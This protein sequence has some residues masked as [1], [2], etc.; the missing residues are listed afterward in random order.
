[1]KTFQSADHYSL[2]FTVIMP[3]C[4]GGDNLRRSLEALATSTR[5]PDEVIV[6]DDSS[7]DGSA[8]MARNYEVKVI[9]ISDGSQGS[10]VARNLGAKAAQGNIL[11]FIDADV[12]VR[13]DTLA[14]IERYLIKHPEIDALFGSYDA[15]PAVRTLVS[16][17][18]NLLHHYVHQHSPREASTFWTGCGAIRRE[19]FDEMGG[20]DISCRTIRD[21]ELGGR[22][23]RAGKQVWLCPEIQVKHL[24]HWKLTTMIR[25]D[26]FDRAIPW[27]RLIVGN[28]SMP[29]ELNL[30]KGNLVSASAAWMT[31]GFLVTGF[32]FPW[33]WIGMVLSM[34]TLG[35][36]NA[37]LYHF[38]F[39]QGGLGFAAGAAGLHFLYLLYSSMTFALISGQTR[40]SPKK[41]QE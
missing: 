7:S 34:V 5:P 29:N 13:S 1:M 36:L 10:Y 30:K 6:I 21:I 25:S 33:A 19:V 39:Q 24:K 3:V 9:S 22:L 4:N 18:K 37:D 12:A 11:V 41:K 38:F 40:L 8:D 27:T 35:V 2:C 14:R 26:I 20:F 28:T 15:D 17:Y 23:R 31:L 32:L 16:R